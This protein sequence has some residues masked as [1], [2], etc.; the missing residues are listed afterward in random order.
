MPRRIT[1][2]MPS[3]ACH[4]LLGQRL[5]LFFSLL[6]D[7]SASVI[8]FCP[9]GAL[10][11]SKS[12]EVFCFSL[13]RCQPLWTSTTNPSTWTMSSNDMFSFANNIR[14]HKPAR[15]KLKTT[16]QKFWNPQSLFVLNCSWIP[17][18]SVL[19]LW[20]PSRQQPPRESAFGRC[21]DS[22]INQIDR[23]GVCPIIFLVYPL[24]PLTVRC[25]PDGCER[26][27]QFI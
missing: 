11:F 1:R 23:L 14:S 15:S 13:L 7:E 16:F 19:S 27:V 22:T 3:W 4:L 6:Q 25:L 21:W 10:F 17:N 20:H 9:I 26:E 5:E 8:C 12:L 2:C 24:Q 18:I